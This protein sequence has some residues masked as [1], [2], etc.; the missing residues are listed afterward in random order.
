VEERFGGGRRG[1]LIKK[2]KKIGGGISILMMWGGPFHMGKQNRSLT[3]ERQQRGGG[4]LKRTRQ[5]G[6]DYTLKKERG[7]RQSSRRLSSK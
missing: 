2:G 1:S 3:K 5:G 4:K 6:A 7:R